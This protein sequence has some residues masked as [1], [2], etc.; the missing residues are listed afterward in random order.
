MLIKTRNNN[1]Y[2]YNKKDGTISYVDSG[3]SEVIRAFEYGSNLN[4]QGIV[5][6]TDYEN[7]YDYQKCTLIIRTNNFQLSFTILFI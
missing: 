6:D 3:L 7:G 2:L 4:K 1:E 5:K